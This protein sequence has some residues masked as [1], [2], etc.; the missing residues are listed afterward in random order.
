MD[1]M[2]NLPLMSV[3]GSSGGG[4]TSSALMKHRRS[5][6]AAPVTSGA[7]GDGNPPDLASLF[8]CPI[9][10]DYVLPPS[11]LASLRKILF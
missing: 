8:E 5:A 2:N 11:K 10:Y 9:C 1:N 3:G 7:A 4:Q 6:A